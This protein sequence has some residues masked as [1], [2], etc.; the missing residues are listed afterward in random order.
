M[1]II[2]NF[3]D[4]YDPIQRWGIDNNIVYNR[5]HV[6][7]LKFSNPK[8]WSEIHETQIDPAILQ[9]INVTNAIDICDT[10]IVKLRRII[11]NAILPTI[12]LQSVYAVINGVIYRNFILID[13]IN[14]EILDKHPTADSVFDAVLDSIKTISAKNIWVDRIRQAKNADS[15]IEQWGRHVYIGGLFSKQQATL[16]QEQIW[17]F[18]RQLDTPVFF[19]I[20]NVGIKHASLAYY[21]F[22]SL[23]DRNIEAI[24]QEIAYCIGNIIS[25]KNE[26]P[27]AISDG[28]KLEQHGFDRRKSFRHRV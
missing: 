21:G 14:N 19:K 22:N 7:G 15:L 13:S 24:A 5:I 18:H 1:K 16:S 26:P 12:R 11:Q 4:Y 17:E 8:K 6:G 10:N 25:D 2:S 27:V 20:G 28:L 23:F 9:H 3:S